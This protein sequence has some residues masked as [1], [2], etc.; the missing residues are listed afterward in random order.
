MQFARFPRPNPDVSGIWFVGCFV[1]SLHRESQE[2]EV[3]GVVD[4]SLQV[5]VAWL[6]SER[7][8]SVDGGREMARLTCGPLQK[9]LHLR[10]FACGRLS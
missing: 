8:K 5:L 1:K 7:V 3:E 6:P 10:L 9:A 4:R 2:V